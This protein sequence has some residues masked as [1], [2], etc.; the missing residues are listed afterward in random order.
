MTSIAE[1][2]NVAYNKEHE[3]QY[4]CN[5]NTINSVYGLLDIDQKGFIVREDVDS[6]LSQI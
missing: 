1:L 6:F 2:I 5:D 4:P 3:E